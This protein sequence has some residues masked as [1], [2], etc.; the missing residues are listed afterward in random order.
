M[1]KLKITAIVLSL[2]IFIV[3]LSKEP[4]NI[5]QQ[6][7]NKELNE[8][9]PEEKI[10][11]KPV[12]TISE[13]VEKISKIDLRS[14]LE[15]LASNE[16]E[17]R[18]SGKKGNKTAAEFIKKKFEDL[19]LTTEYHKFSVKRVNPGPKNEV[20]DDFTQNIYAWIEGNDE[21]LKEEI[22][23]IGAHMDHIGYGPTY[24]RWG[25]G[26]IHNGADDNASG[27]VALIEIAKAF[28]LMKGQNKRTV[29]FMAFSGEEMGLKGSIHYVNNPV[30]PKG[31]PDLKKHV[32]MLNMDMV[33]YLGKS[34][35]SFEN[36][37][38]SADIGLIIKDLGAKYSFAK[39][40]TSRGASGSD[41]APFYNKKI[42][43][44]FI[45]TG[46]HDYYHTPKDTSE[47]I[48]YDGLEKISKYGFELVWKVCNSVEKVDF[49]YGSFNEMDYNHDH[50][51][52]DI[53]FEK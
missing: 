26:K 9:K 42:P 29:V 51:H 30:F 21:K 4:S 24:S 12:F 47:K 53:P 8:K 32:F 49:D 22:V 13:A 6:Q 45:H 36:A 20:G 18:M 34:K 41:H 52:K 39:S 33:G 27:T 44:A 35:V 11:E 25:S 17:G 14:N 5:P 46:L 50:G 19:E 16:L 1:N 23:V 31:N 15:Y 28:S 40:V 48:N 7:E 37:E 3:I 10:Q 43:V 2:F 38:S